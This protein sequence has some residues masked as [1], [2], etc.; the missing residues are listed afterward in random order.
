MSNF[1]FTVLDSDI[2][3]NSL[4]SILFCDVK[5]PTM[6]TSENKLQ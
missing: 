6:F 1:S 4:N 2:K 5:W 3:L